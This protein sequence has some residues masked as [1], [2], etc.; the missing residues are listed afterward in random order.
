LDTE[1]RRSE[2]SLKKGQSGNPRGRPKRATHAIPEMGGDHWEALMLAEAY[3]LVDVTEDGKKI[4][5]PLIQAIMRRCAILAAQGQPRQMRYVLDMLQSI[6][7]TRAADYREYWKTMMNW[8]I[9]VKNEFERRKKMNP[10]EPDPIPHPDDIVVNMNT[11]K[12]KLVG[13]INEEKKMVGS[14]RG[15]R[16]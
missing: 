4:K 9:D 11:G 3:R 2:I 1:N 10:S 15:M 16:S 14:H 5:I 6:E 8:K 7:A 13:P 12:V